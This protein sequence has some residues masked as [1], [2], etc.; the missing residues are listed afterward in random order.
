MS[1]HQ[2]DVR[3][4]DQDRERLIADLREHMAAGR[5]SL[6]ELEQRT[7]SAYAARTTGELDKLRHDLPVTDQQ[8]A[9]AH[10]ARRSRLARRAIQQTGGLL[11]LFLVGTLIWLV[12]GAS[13]QFW[14]VWVLVLLGISAGRSAW[15]LYGPGADLDHFEARLDA[16]RAERGAR[17]RRGRLGP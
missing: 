11:V 4:S 12:D 9:L 10:A 1:E 3:A 15:A 17:R 16:G 5:I 8:A 14:P 2:R 6:D 13:G 7:Q